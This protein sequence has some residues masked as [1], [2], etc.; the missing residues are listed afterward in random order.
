MSN[1]NK[2]KIVL[3]GASGLIGYNCII[4][5]EAAGYKIIIL[6]RNNC[7][8]FDENSIKEFLQHH[9]PQYMLHFAWNT[10]QGYLNSELNYEYKKAGINLLKYFA[11]FGGKK[12]I[13]AGTCLEYK[14]KD[15]PLKET[16]EI[17]PHSL[18]ANT[19]AELMDAGFK[20][21]KDLNFEFGW[22][23]IFNVFGKNEHS[24]RLTA[25]L[26]DNLSNNKIFKLENSNLIRDYMYNIDVANAFVAFLNSNITGIV[27]ISTSK[28]ISLGDYAKIIAEKLNKKDFLILKNKSTDEPRIIIG[29][30]TILLNKIG[31]KLKYDI[32]NAINEII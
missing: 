16:D 21:A 20:L 24:T 22:G 17:C 15:T 10:K 4:P 25:A 13:F 18:Y 3:T 11:K 30:N 27:N 19:K 31:Y 26:I 23:R 1:K 7:S 5:L 8:L 6:N 2:K 14:F 12:A 29:D 9:K 32:S 28:G